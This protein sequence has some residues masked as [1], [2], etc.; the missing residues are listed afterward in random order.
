MKL[1]ESCSFGALRELLVRDRLI[2][3]VKDYRVR[4][5]SL[6]KRDLDLD[7]AIETIKERQVTHARATKISEE[8]QPTKILTQQEKVETQARE[9]FAS[10]TSQQG[11]S[12]D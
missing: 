5:K 10:Q 6:G 2:L 12:K 9:S 4:G 11:P 8:F 7:K 1:S 3:G